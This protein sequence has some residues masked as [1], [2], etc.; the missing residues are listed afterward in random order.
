MPPLLSRRWSIDAE[1]V[2]KGWEVMVG[3][4][5]IWSDMT[6]ECSISSPVFCRRPTGASRELVLSMS[7]FVD[8]SRLGSVRSCEC[9]D[10]TEIIDSAYMSST[11]EVDADVVLPPAS[12]SMPAR[13]PSLGREVDDLSPSPEELRPLSSPWSCIGDRLR[14]PPLP[15]LE[16]EVVVKG[17]EDEDGC[18]T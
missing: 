7:L 8:P 6:W 5:G 14:E 15:I 9:L 3:P 12:G 2:R 18:A 4:V 10:D 17:M 1:S 11:G 16:V 13:P